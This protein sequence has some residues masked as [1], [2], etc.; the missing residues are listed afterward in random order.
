MAPPYYLADPSGDSS[1]GMNFPWISGT[2][3]NPALAKVTQLMSSLESVP[4]PQPP[5]VG[6]M[7]S[8]LGAIGDGLT[9][10]AT[11]RQ[12]GTPQPGIFERA[13]MARQEAY[14]KALDEANYTNVGERNKARID[15]YNQEQETARVRAR[16]EAR[17]GIKVNG[18]QIVNGELHSTVSF[19][20][21]A[22]NEVLRT[23]DTGPIKQSYTY[24]PDAQGNLTQ[25]P[26]SGPPQTPDVQ[27][28]GPQPFI[29][30][31]AAPAIATTGT[32]K[33]GKKT[34]VKVAPKSDVVVVNGP[35]GPVFAHKGGAPSTA[36]TDQNGEP[37]GGKPN[38]GATQAISSLKAM[39]SNMEALKQLYRIAHGY[40]IDPQTGARVPIKGEPPSVV[41][42]TP[43]GTAH[44]F[45]PKVS[46][47]TSSYLMG[48][49]AKHE[50]AKDILSHFASG[51]AAAMHEQLRAVILPAQ[52]R[53]QAG[54]GRAVA[55]LIPLMKE[56]IPS[57]A[58]APDTAELGFSTMDSAAQQALQE[59]QAEFPNVGTGKTET[60][61]K[62]KS[63][64]EEFSDYMAGQKK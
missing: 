56:G 59:L 6:I 34:G 51:E 20:D 30:P 29:G 10:A 4:T 54:N 27:P 12:G 9:T 13:M 22:T 8:I 36:V 47:E 63:L 1:S 58:T 33:I 55:A 28:Q 5:H 25:L 50:F 53:L 39:Q 42:Y 40:Q 48:S 14:R 2:G 24:Q 21:P 35:N 7:R 60:A 15:A 41:I 18:T 31:P 45:H 62:K 44:V 46:S 57:M 16:S 49:A 17:G 43:D 3:D 52:A 11:I 38:L 64:D 37:I 26:T 23:I 32:G 61:G 19:L